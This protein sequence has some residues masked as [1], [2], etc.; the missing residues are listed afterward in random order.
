MTVSI[1]DVSIKYSSYQG[2]LDLLEKILEIGVSKH[3]EK[4]SKLTELQHRYFMLQT[5]QAEKH[6]PIDVTGISLSWREKLS[7]D[8]REMIR[9]RIKACREKS[10]KLRSLYHPDKG[11]DST[12]FDL[13]QK[14]VSV[15]DLEFIHLCLMKENLLEGEDLDMTPSKLLDRIK[16]QEERLMG[17]LLWKLCG[18][19]YSNREEFFSFLEGILDTNIRRLQVALT[20]FLPED[21]I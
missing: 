17:S 15:G 6:I 20:G 5:E 9:S 10:R 18:R 19:Y 11:G 3:L 13:L 7:A 14:A 16:G 4:S 2:K 8:N 21:Q 1:K 12:A